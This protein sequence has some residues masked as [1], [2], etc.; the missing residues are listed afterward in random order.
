[1]YFLWVP[2]SADI[3]YRLRDVISFLIDSVVVCVLA[4]HAGDH[5]SIHGQVAFLVTKKSDVK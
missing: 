2:N 3:K 5:G 4:C 1:M